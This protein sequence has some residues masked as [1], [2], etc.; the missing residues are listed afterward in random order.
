[1]AKT[2]LGTETRGRA[3]WI[4]LGALATIAVIG[5][6]VSLI[7]RDGSPGPASASDPMTVVDTP[8]SSAMPPP[9]SAPPR[10]RTPRLLPGS[11]PDDSVLI[12]GQTNHLT[13]AGLVAQALF[14]YD[15][16]TNFQARNADLLSAAAPAPWGDPEALA[17]DLTRYTP[18]GASLDSIRTLGTTVTVS[19]TGVSVSTWASKKLAA[20][21]AST[22]TYGIDVTGTQTITAR[23]GAP[24]TVP[25]Q[26]GVTVACPPA[27]ESC[28]V[29]RIFPQHLQ[30]ALGSG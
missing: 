17:Q 7:M 16:S 10:A 27:T 22:G 4:S 13:F 3:L 11:S 6:V 20:I 14:A 26:L 9:A 29:D 30:D 18:T 25:V 15:P 23:S 2:S 28:T 12:G 5:T 8:L 19:L 24:V 21:G 1:V